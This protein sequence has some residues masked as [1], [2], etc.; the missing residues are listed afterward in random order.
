M[1]I[2]TKARKWGNSV[3]VILPKIVVE[4]N[5]IKENQ[6]ITIEIIEKPFAGKF[7]GILPRKS[8]KSAQ[9]IKD[10]MRKGW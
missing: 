7:F 6:E 8:K 9:M 3:A 4:A 1:E 5:N 2:K 10:E